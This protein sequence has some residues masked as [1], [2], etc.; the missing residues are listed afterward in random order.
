MCYGVDDALRSI[1]GDSVSGL[2]TG[3]MS[4]KLQAADVACRAGI[5]TIIASGSKPGV[6]GDV[7]EGISVGTRF[8]CASLAAGEPQT[9]DLRRAAGRRNY[10]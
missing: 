3:G 5:D 9:L 4:T 8:S 10:G 6:I 7:M 1:A 2:G